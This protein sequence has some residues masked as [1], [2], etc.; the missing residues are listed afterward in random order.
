M[1]EINIRGLELRGAYGRKTV[2]ADWHSGKDFKIVCGP[3]CSIRDLRG[4]A[5]EFD[6]LEFTQVGGGL[7]ERVI[8]NEGLLALEAKVGG[9]FTREN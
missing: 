5:E 2:M 1:A 6:I 9:T 3:Y 8:I 4:M 7:V